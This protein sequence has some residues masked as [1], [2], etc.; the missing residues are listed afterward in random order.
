MRCLA[1]L[2]GQGSTCITDG[3]PTLADAPA[4]AQP[5]QRQG[6]NEVVVHCSVEQKVLESNPLLEAFGN[7]K[8]LRNNNSSRFGKWV[9]RDGPVCVFVCVCVPVHSK[10]ACSTS[11]NL[12]R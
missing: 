4:S 5:M 10:L 2:G 7:A 11:Q 6:S 9:G 3:P 1:N 12:L 8:T